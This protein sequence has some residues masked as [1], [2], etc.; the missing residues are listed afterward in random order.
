L[1]EK[2]QNK[3]LWFSVVVLFAINILNFYDRHV[4]GAL[5][6]PMRKEFHLSDTQIGLLGSAFIWIYAIIG[7]PLGRIADSASRKKLLAWGVVIWTALTASAGFATTYT[8][9]LF[10]RVGVGVGEA[11]CAP[12][13]TSW[14]GDLFP[15]DKRSRVLALFMLGVPVGGALGYFFSGPL[16]QA[17]GWRAA[18]V[19][20]AVPALL[21]VPALLMLH[22]PRRGASELHLAPLAPDSMWNVLRIPTLWW[23]IASGALLNFNAYAFATFLPAFLSR[24]H[25]LSLAKSGMATGVLYLIGGVTGGTLAGFLGDSIVHRRKDGRML[26]ASVLALTAIPFA[27]IGI[28]QPAGSLYLAMT[29]L[30]LTYASLTTYYGLVYSAIQDIVPPNQRAS[31]MAIYFMAMYMCGASFGPL[32][33]GK[34]SDVL[35]HRAAALAGSGSVTEAFRA[36]GLQ[37]AML[38][39]PVLSTALGFVLYA[40]SRT[41][42]ADIAK[43]EAAAHV[44]T[45]NAS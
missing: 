1:S 13:A 38:I 25:G 30:A 41:I 17:Y 2:T 28:L 42:A 5:V 31:A 8:V 12:T 10:S 34:L 4:P 37:Q 11:A 14:L 33:T 15:P 32:L 3:T 23:I 26:C 44:A 16:A 18:M 7:V 40:G 24:V 21:L 45:V 29:F 22:E 39:I 36:T 6:E 9:L 19:F 27:C 20:A 43:R 35:A